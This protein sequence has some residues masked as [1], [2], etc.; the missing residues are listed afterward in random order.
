VCAPG[1]ST[2]RPPSQETAN[3]SHSDA[4]PETENPNAAA[5][6]KADASRRPA[7]R[8]RS[9]A[10]RRRQRA[11]QGRVVI[12][13]HTDAYTAPKKRSR[14][15]DKSCCRPQCGDTARPLMSSGNRALEASRAP[16]GLRAPETA[17]HKLPAVVGHWIVPNFFPP[18]LQVIHHQS[19]GGPTWRQ[20]RSFQPTDKFP[21]CVPRWQALLSKV[22]HL[23]G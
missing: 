13:V 20:S 14:F 6:R 22:F 5:L 21:L 19:L 12:S 11:G 1:Y 8:A 7:D 15:D 23:I 3:L 16:S 10:K 4:S 17:T 9:M 18:S 2:E